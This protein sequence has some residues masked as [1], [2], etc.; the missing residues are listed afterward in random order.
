[1]KYYFILQYRRTIREIRRLGINPWVG[2]I[3][4]LLLFVGFSIVLFQKTSLA[5]YVYAVMGLSFVAAAG[6]RRKNQFLKNIFPRNHFRQIRL[7]ENAFCAMPFIIF[8]LIRQS[9][10][11]AAALAVVSM[12][13]SFYNHAGRTRFQIPSPFSKFPYE[14]TVGF[15]RAWFLFLA[16]A[17]LTG[18]AVR[19][20]NFNLGVAGFLGFFFICISFYSDN[21]PLFFVWIYARCPRDFLTGKIKT[22]LR[23]GFLLSLPWLATLAI[24]NPGRILILFLV[25]I[26]GLLYIVLAVVAA[27]TSFPGQ[28][29]I[30]RLLQFC[31]ALLFPPLLLLVIPLFFQR[32]VGRLKTYLPC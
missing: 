17:V 29:S 3:S 13:L 25:E 5:P 23:Y 28:K 2:V 16:S 19:Y 20:Q 4:F 12:L 27:Y 11:A 22:A 31:V 14:F 15:R 8:L 21:D 7:L 6:E 24:F 9:W 32:A 1:M 26:T 18:I 10:P 30:T